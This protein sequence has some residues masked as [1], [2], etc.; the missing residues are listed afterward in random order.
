MVIKKT[1]GRQLS[2]HRTIRFLRRNRLALAFIL[3]FMVLGAVVFFR[4][5]ALVPSVNV[6]AERGVVSA[7]VGV[8]SDSTA[9]GGNYVAFSSQKD[10]D[11]KGEYFNN[12]YLSGS[13]ALVRFDQNIDFD[14]GTGS[15]DPI[16][17]AER[18]SVRWTATKSFGGQTYRFT[19]GG[20][21]GI[22]LKI[23][24]V[25]VIDQWY[26]QYFTGFSYDVAL[27]G[28]HTIEVDYYEDSQGAQAYFNYGAVATMC[29]STQIGTLPNCQPSL[30]PIGQVGVPPNC[31]QPATGISWSNN[32][33]AQR[34][35]GVGHYSDMYYDT[36]RP[37]MAGFSQ[38][39]T[40]ITNG[41]TDGYYFAT[42]VFFPVVPSCAGN[43]CYA[44]MGLQAN[45]AN[46]K[47]IIFSIWAS[48]NGAP[49]PGV[50]QQAF[51]GEGTGLSLRK[52]FAWIEGR[53]YRYHMSY[54]TLR[55]DGA[56]SNWWKAW[57]E[58][59]TSGSVTELG[60]L[61]LPI[62]LRYGNSVVSFHERFSGP[63]NACDIATVNPSKVRFENTHY[64]YPDGSDLLPVSGAIYLTDFTGCNNTFGVNAFGAGAVES[65]VMK[66]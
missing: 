62:G 31:T 39:V 11:F 27:S 12:V 54:D 29:P 36:R 51:G 50:T 7:N 18:F 26:N 45:S 9:S 49:A 61:Q 66:P 5:S 55:S 60:S 15:P 24:G 47:Q 3:G 10:T 57:L 16:I 63:V 19:I 65:W 23:D 22:R 59:T 56:N 48:P 6:E 43:G 8:V 32:R 28:A 64:I 35:F 13:P 14:W 2:K 58:D 44:Y 17:N 25:M 20:D 52:P 4:S 1:R 46:G 41:G 37:D 53:K 30:C 33:S 21:D 38:D 42:Q 34:P 40:V